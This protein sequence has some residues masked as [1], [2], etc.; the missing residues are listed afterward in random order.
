MIDIE[1]R[2][3]ELEGLVISIT[4]GGMNGGLT[5]DAEEAD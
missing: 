2:T 3:S 1:K 4:E 5:P